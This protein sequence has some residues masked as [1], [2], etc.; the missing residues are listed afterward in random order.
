MKMFLKNIFAGFFLEVGKRLKLIGE[1]M[2]G[3]K[4]SAVVL[5]FLRL[6]RK[7]YL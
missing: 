7:G 6:R 2:K 3:L 1:K 4:Y 5:V